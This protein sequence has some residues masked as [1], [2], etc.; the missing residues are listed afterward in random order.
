[1]LFRSSYTWSR[2]I[3]DSSDLQTLLLPQDVNNFKAERADSL[4]DQRQRFVFS[5]V[6]ASPGAWRTGSSVRRFFSD[7]TVAPIVELSSGRPFNVITNVD[8][9]NDQSSQTD[10]PSVGNGY[11]LC[12]PGTTGCFTP[13]IQNYQFATGNLG[14]NMGILH[15]FMS[16]DMRVARAIRKIGRAHV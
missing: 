15:G 10:R 16:I 2:S 1:M 12:V 9:N 8:T 5:G 11:Q 13:L 3:D 14:R 4:F 6:I 7:F